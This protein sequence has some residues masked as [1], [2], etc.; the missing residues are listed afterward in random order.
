MEEIN[1]PKLSTFKKM[2]IAIVK[3]VVKPREG[4]CGICHAIAEEI[5]RVG[6]RIVA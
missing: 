2:L 3:E 6:G 4:A 1:V 5:C